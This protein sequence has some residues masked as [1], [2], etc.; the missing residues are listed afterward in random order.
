MPHKYLFLALAILLEVV[1]SAFLTASYGF[2]KRIPSVMAVVAY[3]LCFYFL[4][5]SL[6]E[7]PLGIVY[8][9][10]AG[11]GMILTALVSVF[12]FKQPLDFAAF[13]GIA[14]IVLGVFIIQYFS[15]SVH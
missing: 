1:G 7:L 10:W 13:L 6:K 12:I 11:I 8:A 5:L 4:S 15:K 2:S 9:L 14:F 3:V